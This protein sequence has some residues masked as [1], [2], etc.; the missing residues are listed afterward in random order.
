MIDREFSP[1]QL[2]REAPSRRGIRRGLLFGATAL[3][4]VTGTGLAAPGAQASVPG[5]LTQPSPSPTGAPAESPTEGRGP[6]GHMM[7]GPL[8]AVHGE[9][10]IPKRG[11]GYQTVTTQTGKVTS[12]NRDSVALKSTDGFA[13]TYR[14]DA[15]TRVCAGRR[16]L[17]EVK[18]GDTVWVISPGKENNSTAAL[19]VDLTR[20]QWPAGHGG[21]GSPAPTPSPS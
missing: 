14:I 7:E 5:N 11:G 21:G 4:F 13:R 20:P 16:G 17:D 1:S 15:S 8:G 2:P 9:L 3:L 19:L 12:I 6:G 10:V 18:A